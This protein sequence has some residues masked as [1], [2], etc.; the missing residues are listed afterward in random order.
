MKFKI[1]IVTLLFLTHTHLVVGQ[2]EYPYPSLSP[3]GRIIQVVGNTNVEIAYERPSVRN[4]AI[5]G[6]VVPWNKVWRTGAGFCTK[7]RFDQPVV[8][9]GQAVNPGKYSLFTIPN[10]DQW[11]VILNAD[12]TLYGSSNY[13]P[14]MDVT[15]FTVK[16]SKS[17]RFYETLT[18]DIDLIPNNARIYMSWEETQ[19]HFDLKTTTDEEILTFIEE[20]LLTKKDKNSNTY[21]GAAEYLHYQNMNSFEAIELTQIAIELDQTNGWARRLNMEIYEKLSMYEKALQSANQALNYATDKET[22]KRH[23]ER[24]EQ[25]LESTSK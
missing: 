17:P 7:I 20:Q 3:K 9:G 21:A 10:P 22:W 5:F 24:L 14:D 13:N 1:T 16:P 6:D 25:K 18:F 23:I 19:I 11:I 8:I 4:R 15:R 12:T 2:D